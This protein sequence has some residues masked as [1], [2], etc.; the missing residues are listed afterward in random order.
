MTPTQI[1]RPRGSARALVALATSIL[2]ASALLTLLG[3]TAL[4]ADVGQISITKTLCVTIGDQDTCNGRD[5]SLSGYN[6]DFQVHSGTTATG[7]VVQTITVTMGLNAEEGGNTGGGSQGDETGAALPFGDYVVCEIPRAYKAGSPDVFLNALPRPDASGGGSTGGSQHQVAEDCIGFTLASGDEQLKFLDQ[8]LHPAI[9]IVKRASTNSLP[10]GGGPV[11]Y[12]Y[13]VSNPGDMP[14]TGVT[15]SDDKCSPVTRT[16]GDTDGD[17]KLDTNETWT[18][19]CTTTITVTTTNTGTADSNETAPVTDQETVTVA[20][21]A[22][23]IA[24]VKRASPTTLPAGGGSVTYTYTVTNAGN[25]PLTGVSVS[26]DK[27]EPVTYQSGD[28]NEDD[29]LDT[30]ESWIFTCTTTITQTTTNVGTADSNETDPVTDSETVVVAPS[31]PAI[32]IVKS[33]STNDLP[34][35]GGSVTYTYT[36]T[37]PGNIALTG[38]T[39]SDDKCSPV[40]RTGGDVNTN[41]ILEQSETWTYTCTTTLTVTTTNVGTADSNETGPATDTETV[42]VAR[43]G[44][45]AETAT[46]Q[47]PSPTPPQ[48]STEDP[49]GGGGSPSL[50]LV[51]FVLAA[52]V[53]GTLLLTPAPRRRSRR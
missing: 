28:A 35:G 44:T 49:M 36:V 2:A 45:L 34:V 3:A 21:E 18:Y 30:S 12:T 10:V 32:A 8:K 31:A 25:I 16:G 51:L 13:E 11:T 23:A 38:V 24:I 1:R 42:T 41:D 22:P 33:A 50:A 52:G 26:D 9:A 14:L 27:C 4:A 47:P 53:V 6:I 48:T 7:P 29:K 39:V 46:P 37:N 5:S 15:V 40:T 43:E 19:T 17:N 20:A